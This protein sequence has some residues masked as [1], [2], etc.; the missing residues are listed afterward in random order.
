LTGFDVQVAT[1]D[2][3]KQSPCYDEAL[4]MFLEVKTVCS[5]QL[6]CREGVL[7]TL[8]ARHWQIQKS[9]PNMDFIAQ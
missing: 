5:S 4:M 3:P 1:K 9:T 7:Q 8:D 6:V 2:G